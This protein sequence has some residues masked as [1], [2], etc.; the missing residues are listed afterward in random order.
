MV[1]QPISRDEVLRLVRQRGPLIPNELRK[2]LGQGDTMLVGAVL[3]ELANKGLVRISKTKLGGSPFYYDPEKPASLERAGEHLNEKDQRTWR[4][5]KEKRVLRDDKQEALTRVSLRN[6]TD[7][8]K[9]LTINAPEGQLT[10]WKYYLVDDAEAERRIKTELGLLEEVKEPPTTATPQRTERTEAP[11][12]LKEGERE[13]TVA[14]QPKERPQAPERPASKPAPVATE[15]LAEDGERRAERPV[16]TPEAARRRPARREMGMQHALPAAI[17]TIDDEFYAQVKRYF[18]KHTITIKEQQLIRK[19]SEVDFVILLPTP[20]GNVEYYCKAKA[21][22]RSN[23]G[24]LASA[25]LQGNARN[26]PVLYLTTGE[27]TKKAKEMLAKEFK[28]LVVK[29]L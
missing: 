9:E 17:G 13:K 27:I 23:D 7:F 12:G 29:E 24:D 20:V 15:A 16:E 21:K 11:S 4:L 28:G 2:L 25:K 5:L 1:M 6:I 26:L 22:K 8:S 19:K 14:E 18:D 10:Y 3:S